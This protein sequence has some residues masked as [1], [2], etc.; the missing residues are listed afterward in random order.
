MM[1]LLPLG[2]SDSSSSAA[3]PRIATYGNEFGKGTEGI[4]A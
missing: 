2:G 1:M 3:T 4:F